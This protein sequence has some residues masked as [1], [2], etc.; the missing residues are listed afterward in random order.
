MRPGTPGEVLSYRLKLALTDNL[1]SFLR[2]DTAIEGVASAVGGAYGWL[3]AAIQDLQPPFWL[4]AL[5]L[6]LSFGSWVLH[7]PVRKRVRGSLT[8]AAQ[9]ASATRHAE[10]AETLPLAP[11]DKE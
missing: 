1:P 6:L 3:C 9:P 10:T 2:S 7:R 8:L 4:G 11:Q 5:L